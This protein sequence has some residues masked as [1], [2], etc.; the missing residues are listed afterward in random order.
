MAFARHIPG[1]SLTAIALVLELCYMD[2]SDI[3]RHVLFVLVREG[4][5]EKRA[6]EKEK[7]EG[8]VWGLGGSNLMLSQSPKREQQHL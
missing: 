6:R 1:C 8:C 2:K 4:Q 5:R 7:D 3:S